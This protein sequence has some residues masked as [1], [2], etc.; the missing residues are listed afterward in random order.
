MLDIIILIY[1]GRDFYNLAIKY[2]KK[3]WV[4]A[5][6]GVASTYAGIML[7]GL[8]LGITIEI[9]SPGFIDESNP[10]LLGIMA[11]PFGVLAWWLLR[12]MLRK[13]WSKPKPIS[14]G[15]LDGDLINNSDTRQ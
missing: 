10:R 8:I 2:D 5:V 15:T 7:G 13:S 14:T 3:G 1:V 11:V 6:V 12:T 4:Y 9:I